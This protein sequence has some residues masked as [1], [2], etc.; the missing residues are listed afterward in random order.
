M[1]NNNFKG[2]RREGNNNNRQERRKKFDPVTFTKNFDTFEEGLQDIRSKSQEINAIFVDY[3][4]SKNI[5]EVLTTVAAKAAL[6]DD[7]RANI[8]EFANPDTK[9]YSLSISANKVSYRIP[10]GIAFGWKVSFNKETKE[11][12][13]TFQVIISSYTTMKYMGDLLKDAG[14]ESVE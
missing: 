13:Y 7:V 12:S 10:N 9:Y 4:N 11:T 1:R 14:Y 3:E 8:P 2:Q 6:V 5:E